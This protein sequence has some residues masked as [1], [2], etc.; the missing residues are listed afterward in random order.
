MF[1]GKCKRESAVLVLKYQ[2]ILVP[3]LGSSE[4]AFEV[5]VDEFPRLSGFN[6]LVSWRLMKLLNCRFTEEQVVHCAQV[7]RSSSTDK[8]TFLL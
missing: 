8:C 2:K 4:K 1:A 7:W 3:S 6:Q 5:D